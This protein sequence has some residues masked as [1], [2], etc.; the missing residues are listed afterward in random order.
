MKQQRDIEKQTSPPMTCVV[1]PRIDKEVY[2]GSAYPWTDVSPSAAGAACAAESSGPVL[3][4][5]SAAGAG[6]GGADAP[7]GGVSGASVHSAADPLDVFV[8]G[9]QSGP[10]LPGGGGA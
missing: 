1:T 7:R 5:A 3:W 2:D 10:F 6:H 9:A 8:S 4:P